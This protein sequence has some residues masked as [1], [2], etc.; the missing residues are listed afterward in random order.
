VLLK[1]AAEG[2]GIIA[3]GAVR[4]LCEC[5]G[6]KDILTKSLGSKNSINVLKATLDGLASLKI[7]NA[8]SNSDKG[9]GGESEETGEKKA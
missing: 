7:V 9:V 3:G 2:T 1:P 8:Q 6:I 4:A 5:S